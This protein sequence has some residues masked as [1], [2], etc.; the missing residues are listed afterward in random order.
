MTAAQVE[1]VGVYLRNH[2]NSG[3]LA[4]TNDIEPFD[5]HEKLIAAAD[6][7]YLYTLSSSHKALAAQ[8]LG[9]DKD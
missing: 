4:A 3:K 8:I 2:E 9:K 1:I 6:M 7:L 5:S